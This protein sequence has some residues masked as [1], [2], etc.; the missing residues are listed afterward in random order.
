MTP[1]TPAST[2]IETWIFIRRARGTNDEGGE[3][4]PQRCLHGVE[5]HPRMPSS[6]AMTEVVTRLSPGAHRTQSRR[7]LSAKLAVAEQT[8]Q[9]AATHHHHHH[10]CGGLHCTTAP[11]AAL[12]PTKSTSNVAE[13]ARECSHP[14]PPPRHPLLRREPVAGDADRPLLATT[15]C[16]CSTSLDSHGAAARLHQREEAAPHAPEQPPGAAPP[17]TTPSA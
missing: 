2:K 6:P 13:T 5:V 9:H 7:R 16:S 10:H 1:S 3:G 8:L 15:S 4:A 11:H 17:A 14:G 12:L